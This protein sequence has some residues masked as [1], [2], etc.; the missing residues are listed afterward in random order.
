MR[1]F[2]S[3]RHAQRFLSTHA[4]FHNRFQLRRHCVTAAHHRAARAAAFVVWREVTSAA[5]AP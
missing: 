2:K 4:R 5:V 1:R 3:A